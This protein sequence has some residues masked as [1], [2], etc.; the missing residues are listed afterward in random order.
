MTFEWLC[1]G[2]RKTVPAN[3]G[4]TLLDVVLENELDIDGFGVFP[5]RH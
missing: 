5:F 4:D 2:V 3:V 1:N